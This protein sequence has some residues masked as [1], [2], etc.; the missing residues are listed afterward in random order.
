MLIGT[1]WDLNEIKRGALLHL[2]LLKSVHDNDG[3]NV[4][5]QERG[6]LLEDKNI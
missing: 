2:N 3:N 4:R 6:K 1:G 5:P